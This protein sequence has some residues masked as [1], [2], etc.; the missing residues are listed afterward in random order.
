MASASE[1]AEGCC[2][3]G[4]GEEKARERREPLDLELF[5]L[6]REGLRFTVEGGGSRCRVS[7][8]GFRSVFVFWGL[9]SGV[10]LDLELFAFGEEHLVVHLPLLAFQPQPLHLFRHKQIEIK[11]D[12]FFHRLK[13]STPR[14][15]RLPDRQTERTC[16]RSI[17]SGPKSLAPV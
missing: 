17:S 9:G 10:W 3:R 2:G 13:L 5:A 8:F 14:A 11:L 1:G 16:S 6:G 15:S 7:C 4:A 12:E